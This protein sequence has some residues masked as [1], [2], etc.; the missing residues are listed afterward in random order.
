[1]LRE[2]KCTRNYKNRSQKLL[3]DVEQAGLIHMTSNTTDSIGFMCN[4]DR[5]H[6]TFL[7]AASRESKPGQFFNSGFEPLT[8]KDRCTSCHTCIERCPINAR[9][10]DENELLKTDLDRC[11]GCAVC[12]TG[13][14][15]NAIAMANKP[16]FPE[17]PQNMVALSNAIKESRS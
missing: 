2:I 7:K 8:D 16:G 14:P 6:C 13:C 12:A 9:I 15:S 1:M 17:L 5:W 4:C 3:N 10:M 11:F